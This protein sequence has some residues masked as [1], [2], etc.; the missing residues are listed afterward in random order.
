LTAFEEAMH[1]DAPCDAHPTQPLIPQTFAILRGPWRSGGDPHRHLVGAALTHV[2]LIR[3]HNEDAWLALPEFG[4]FAVADGMGG[5]A[6]GEVA[7]N[8][9]IDALSQLTGA[10]STPTGRRERLVA[11]IAQANER[12]VRE[13]ETR[14]ERFGLGTTLAALWIAG[15]QAVVAHIGD[16]RIYRWRAGALSALTLDHSLVGD[17]VR[18]GHL[19]QAQ[20]ERW[21]SSP[22]ITRHLGAGPEAHPDVT[23]VPIRRGDRLLLCTDGLSDAVP[24]AQIARLLSLTDLEEVARGLTQASLDR[25]GRDNITSL[26]IEIR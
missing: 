17:A 5:H 3:T 9:A 25:G 19:T 12:I 8:L 21:P 16:S 1:S 2:G 7:A 20:A 11:A 13:G 24:A 10:S 4:L 23:V 6:A 18:A 26:I 22:M 15:A 14:P